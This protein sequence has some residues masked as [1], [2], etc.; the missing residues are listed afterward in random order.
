MFN[1]RTLLRFALHVGALGFAGFLPRAMAAMVRPGMHTVKG[2]VRVNGTPVVAGAAVKPGD[3]VTTGAGGQAVLVIDFNAYLVRDDSEIIFPDDE[4][5]VEAVLR[6]VSGRIM[7]VFGPGPLRIDMPL[8]TIGI[9][10]TGIYLEVYPERNYV[11]LCYGR[12]VLKSKLEPRVREALNTTHHEGPRNFHADPKAR[13]TKFIE[14]A[15]MVNHK[16]TELIMLEALVGRIPKFGD[17][18]IKMPEG[19]YGKN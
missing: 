16:D 2:D 9:R 7:S 8:A 4:D 3:K 14:K 6:V 10:G 18:P 19:S 15:K 13:G 11:C 1:R 17:K 5:G 12:A